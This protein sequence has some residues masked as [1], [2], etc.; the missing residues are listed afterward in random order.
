LLV[1]F[2]GQKS[3]AFIEEFVVVVVVVGVFSSWF[4]YLFVQL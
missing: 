3:E 2:L 1:F 4:C